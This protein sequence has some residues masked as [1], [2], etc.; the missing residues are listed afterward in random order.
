MR[1]P[2]GGAA[3]QEFRL[4]TEFLREGS[5][6][7][8]DGGLEQDAH[9]SKRKGGGRAVGASEDKAGFDVLYHP[10][11]QVLERTFFL[12]RCGGNKSIMKDLI[13]TSVLSTGRFP[14]SHTL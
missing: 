8:M 12:E 11:A 2:P 6:T 9:Q 5:W 1:G 3:G 13:K 14:D 4:G 10:L 7:H